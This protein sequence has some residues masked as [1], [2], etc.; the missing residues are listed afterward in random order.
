M[1]KTEERGDPLALEQINTAPY[2]INPAPV[3]SQN[4]ANRRNKYSL[5]LV[6]GKFFKVLEHKTINT[7]VVGLCQKCLPNIVE[8][9][10]QLSSSSSFVTH[11][12]RKHGNDV[13]EE[14]RNYLKL[15][16]YMR[17]TSQNIN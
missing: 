12:K 17:R 2:S 15:K 7:T 3:Y 13:L 11:L 8:I 16:K 10:E 1:T 9:R 14:Y 4:N 5:T 6:D